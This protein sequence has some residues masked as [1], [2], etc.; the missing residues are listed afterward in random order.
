MKESACQVKFRFG[1]DSSVQGERA[2]Y[3]PVP[4]VLDQSGSSSFQHTPS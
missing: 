4:Q 1:N 2:V 3:F